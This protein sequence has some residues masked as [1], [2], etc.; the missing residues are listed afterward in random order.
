MQYKTQMNT[1]NK[2]LQA[3]FLV[4]C[5]ISTEYAFAG[6]PFITDDPE[7]VAEKNWEV[8]YA[9]SK[10]WVEGSTS[11][12]FPSIDVNYGY[13]DHI[14]LH[15]QSRY[16]YQTEGGNA[17]SGFDN[18]EIGVKYR[19]V[20][21]E[22]NGTEFMLGIYPM[23]QLPTGDGKLGA[24]SGKTQVFLPVW[25]QVNYGKW[26]LYGGTGY[27][28]NHYSLATNSWF[29]GATALYTLS[30]NLKIGGELFRESTTIKGDQHSSGFNL[31]GIYNFSKDYGLL[32]S[33]GHALNNV[34]ETNKLSAFFAL[35]VVY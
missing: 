1:I 15:I 9:I 25:G 2:I 21:L 30:D 27:R 23:L 8:N 19:F 4:M 18:T 20:H 11:A 3:T 16:T 12:A 32:F 31:G 35:Q 33:A 29:L 24:A 6:A 10:A 5:F 13:S 7:P 22:N 14:Q 17:Q 34:A 28:L 26:T